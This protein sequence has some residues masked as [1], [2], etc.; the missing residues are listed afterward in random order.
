MIFFHKNDLGSTLELS[1]KVFS[2]W[3]ST[4]YKIWVE[5]SVFAIQHIENW[6]VL[7]KYFPTPVSKL[8]LLH[9]VVVLNFTH[10]LKRHDWPRGG[11]AVKMPKN[12]LFKELIRNLLCTN[13]YVNINLQW[14]IS[15]LQLWLRT[16]QLIVNQLHLISTKIFTILRSKIVFI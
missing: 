14:H 6:K 12:N 15:E 10:Q 13:L 9:T 3:T 5:N 4:S 16:K 8:I 11:G 1:A 7:P 2:Q